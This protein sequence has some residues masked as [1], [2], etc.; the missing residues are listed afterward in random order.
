MA[1]TYETI[2]RPYDSL[3]KREAN[4]DYL[5]TSLSSGSTIAD[6]ANGSSPAGSTG[7]VET[8]NVTSPQSLGDVWINTFIKS[9]NWQPK[10]QGFYID[11]LTGYAE[12]AN[13]VL[14]GNIVAVGGTIGGWTIGASTLSSGNVTLDAGNQ[15]IRLGAATSPTVGEGIFMGF[16]SPD[17]EFRVGD[18]ADAYLH[19]TGSAME[20]HGGVITN[21]DQESDLT[22]QGWQFTGVFSSTDSNT[23]E[24][25]TGTLTFSTGVVAAINAGNTGNMSARTYIYYDSASSLVNLQTTTTAADAVG[26][27]KVLIA[28]AENNSDATKESIFQ[29]FGGGGGMNPFI[30]GGNIAADSIT[31]NEIVANSITAAEIQVGSITADRLGVTELSAISADMGDLTAGT[32]T[33]PSG[34]HVKSGQTAYDT[35]TG[36]WLGN[37]GSTKFSIGDSAADKL[38]WT[39]TTLEITG[40]ITGSVITGGTIR[41]DDNGDYILLNGSTNELELWDSNDKVA[42]V[43][44]GT[45]SGEVGFRIRSYDDSGTDEE[46]AQFEMAY[47]TSNGDREMRMEVLTQDGLMSGLRVTSDAS[48]VDTSK[49][50]FS[51]GI[52]TRLVSDIDPYEDETVDLGNSSLKYEDIW[53]ATIHRT[54]ESSPSDARLKENITDVPY[55]LREILDLKPVAFDW[56]H[57]QQ[58]SYGFIAQELAETM[59]AFVS[60]ITDK[61]PIEKTRVLEPAKYHRG[62]KIKE[63]RIDRYVDGYTVELVKPKDDPEGEPL[64]QIEASAIIPVL[65]KALQEMSQKVEALQKEVGELKKKQKP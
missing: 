62:R 39:G 30:E 2:D 58:R 27:N 40:N 25:T 61:K 5:E 22:L 59:P 20:L 53:C 51:V 48:N 64:L 4:T 24:W 10:K 36:F 19:W 15:Q 57:N 16:D 34:G 9:T 47:T 46:M 14:S 11:G 42:A 18:P 54:S 13:I 33:L 1:E 52:N 3:M 56:K 37:D 31:A 63:A 55:G 43:I 44:P 60:P 28:V 29:V 65:V 26:T 8:Q 12:F 35:G 50:E 6:T 21:I 7:S 17:Y 23:V 41:T 32:I 49:N 45:G 38:L